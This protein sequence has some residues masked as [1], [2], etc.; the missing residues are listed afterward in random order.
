[1]NF[2]QITSFIALAALALSSQLFAASGTLGPNR[3]AT[4]NIVPTPKGENCV[5]ETS[6]MRKNHMD[7][8]LHKRDETM[9]KGIRTKKYSITECINCHATPD[10]KGKIARISDE[11]SKHFCSTC[12]AAAAVTLDCFECHADRPISSF[13]KSE[14]DALKNEDFLQILSHRQSFKPHAAQFQSPAIS[15]QGNL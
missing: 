3:D 2:K 10:E 1:V 7:L 8:L 14:I 15:Q 6:Y 9:H 5:E 11:N 12:H 4:G 13:K